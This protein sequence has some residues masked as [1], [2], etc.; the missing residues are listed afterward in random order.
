MALNSRIYAL[1]EFGDVWVSST[2]LTDLKKIEKSNIRAIFC[3]NIVRPY[4]LD[5]EGILWYIFEDSIKFKVN[6]SFPRFQSFSGAIRKV[7]VDFDGNVWTWNTDDTKAT[8]LDLPFQ[9]AI[10]AFAERDI[11]KILSDDGKLW[12]YTNEDTPIRLLY[13]DL[14]PLITVSVSGNHSIA[15]TEDGEAYGWGSNNIG[16]LGLSQRCITIY[17][18]MKIAVLIGGI[19]AIFTGPYTVPRLERPSSPEL[20]LPH[21]YASPSSVSA[22][23]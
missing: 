22:I 23:E 7:G 4:C 5:S 8:K 13:P 15:L 2:H 10:G 3:N 16:Q 21:P 6:K 12:M 14:P 18:P 9:Y 19:S 1:D 11:I 20:L 17:T